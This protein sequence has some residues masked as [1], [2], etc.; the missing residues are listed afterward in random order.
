M[1]ACSAGSWAA[2]WAAWAVAPSKPDRRTTERE[3][4]LHLDSAIHLSRPSASV[5]ES[6]ETRPGMIDEISL[7]LGRKFAASTADCPAAL[8]A[9]RHI[10]LA[11]LT[12]LHLVLKSKSMPT[13][14][15]AQLTGT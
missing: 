14:Q 5:S 15:P 3:P 10:A 8:S 6:D 4:M 13:S 2:S 7:M 11:D 12:A 9:K 1:A